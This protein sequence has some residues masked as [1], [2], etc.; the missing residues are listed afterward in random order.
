MP[1]RIVVH[2]LGG[3]PPADDT[4]VEVTG[5]WIPP[6]DPYAHGV[7]RG[8]A[9]LVTAQVPVPQPRLPYE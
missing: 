4:W 2:G 6:S 9:L 8:A 7:E 5:R 3:P 1:F